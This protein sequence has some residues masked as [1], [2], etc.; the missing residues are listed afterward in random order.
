MN[1]S[2]EQ[3]SD[4]KPPHKWPV[5]LS[6]WLGVPLGACLLYVLSIG[7]AVRL[8]EEGWLSRIAVGRMYRPFAL[9]RG[10]PVE[11]L[12]HSYVRLWLPPPPEVDGPSERARSNPAR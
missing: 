3:A 10:T 6:L 11:R 7:P 9:I 1:S 5:A 4:S 12:V 8:S 2:P